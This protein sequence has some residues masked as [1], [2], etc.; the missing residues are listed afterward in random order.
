MVWTVHIPFGRHRARSHTPSVPTET[1][2]ESSVGIPFGQLL[3]QSHTPSDWTETG[4]EH[5]AGF[6]SMENQTTRN[7]QYKHPPIHR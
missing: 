2:A 3:A 7:L 4:R 5:L 1:G 6:D